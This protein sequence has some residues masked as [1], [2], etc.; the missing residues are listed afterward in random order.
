MKVASSALAL[1]GVIVTLIGFF[2]ITGSGYGLPPLPAGWVAAMV[3]M[4]VGSACIIS[5]A[6]LYLHIKTRSKMNY[7]L[8]IALGAV[9]L[10]L[11][12]RTFI[13]HP[14]ETPNCPCARGFYGPKCLPCPCTIHGVCDDGGEGSGV[15]LCDRG[16]TGE[17]CDTCATNYQGE[18]CDECKRG[19]WKP[20]TG[21]KECHP[22]YVDSSTGSCNQCGSTWVAETDD[23]GVLCRKCKPSHWG[24]FCK[25]ANDTQCKVDGDS[26]AFARDNEWH[27][28][29]VYTGEICTTAGDICSSNYDCENS[30]NCKGI[31]VSG[32]IVDGNTCESDFQCA[33]DFTCQYK[34]CCLEEKFGDGQCTCGRSGYVFDGVTCKKCPGFDGVSSASICSGHGTCAA[35]YSGDPSSDEIVGLRCECTPLDAEP[36]PAFSGPECGCLKESENATSCSRCQDGFYG[37]QCNSCPGGAGIGQCNKH[38][39][40]NDGLDGDGTC[41]CDIDIKYGGLG[42]F[43]G[44]SCSECLSSDFYGNQCHICPSFLMVGCTSSFLNTIPGTGSCSTS[45][46][47]NTCNTA[48]GICE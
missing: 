7:I 15:C 46:G 19:F 40:C 20:Q 1:V 21:C 36:F 47:Q 9:I 11:G 25:Y 12:I 38:G 6:S 18:L 39:I 37:P 33:T 24:A 16:W 29:N 4:C 30:Y 35:A 23:L 31:C 41:T 5:G 8:N 44:A 34:T 28:D 26:L 17:N 22:G 13:Y 3:F 43:K 10:G 2:L 45:C 42:A 32:D 27:D 48:N 14:L